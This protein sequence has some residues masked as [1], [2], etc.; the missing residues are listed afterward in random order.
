[1]LVGPVG[2]LPHRFLPCPNRA[3]N[4]RR[5]FQIDPLDFLDAV[6][7]AERR[8]EAVLGLFHSHPDGQLKLSA[9]D[10]AQAAAW[11]GLDWTIV[12][13]RS[14]PEGPKVVGLRTYPAEEF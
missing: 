4:P 1:M 5:S 6:R 14:V 2:G 13:L 3:A 8:G 10:R 7:K 11:R 12:A 9:E